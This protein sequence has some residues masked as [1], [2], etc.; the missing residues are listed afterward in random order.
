MGELLRAQRTSTSMRRGGP[1]LHRSNRSHKERAP[2]GARRPRVTNRGT[3]GAPTEK[4]ERGREATEKGNTGDPSSTKCPRERE[5]ERGAPSPS[6]QLV[7]TTR[8]TTRRPFHKPTQTLSAFSSVISTRR[9]NRGPKIANTN[10]DAFTSIDKTHTNAGSAHLES[11][12]RYH[13]A[14]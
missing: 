2:L 11:P 8:G 12:R 4:E 10:L 9:E 5:R 7:R 3:T 1:N 14:R 6:R 13:A